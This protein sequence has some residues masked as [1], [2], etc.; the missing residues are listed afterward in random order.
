M[1]SPPALNLHP[2]TQVCLRDFLPM[3]EEPMTDKRK[4]ETTTAFDRATAPVDGKPTPKAD[5]DRN[6]EG[7][8]GGRPEVRGGKPVPD[9]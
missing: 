1:T 6:R 8:Y 9:K 3:M 2:G 7:I 5:Y 4:D